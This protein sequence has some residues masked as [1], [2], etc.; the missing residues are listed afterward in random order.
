MNVIIYQHKFLTLK[1]SINITDIHCAYGFKDAPDIRS[2]L[3]CGVGLGT[4]YS[5]EYQEKKLLM[6]EIEK[7]TFKIRF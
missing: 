4:G 5:A 7:Q 6:K 3:L 2:F 1:L